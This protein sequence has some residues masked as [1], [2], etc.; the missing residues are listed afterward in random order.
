MWRRVE[1]RLMRR[2][3][4]KA[5]LSTA[6]A[7]ACAALPASAQAWS[8]GSHMATGAI[9]FDDLAADNPG[10]IAKIERIIVA[11]PH[12]DLLAEKAEGLQGTER[13]RVI[14]QWLARWP[15][16]IR[17][18]P[19]FDCYECHYELR[20]VSG[21]IWLWPFRN[22]DA[23]EAY[24]RHMRI[25]A[26]ESAPDR[27][28]AI[29]ISWIM[30]IVGDIQQPLHAGHQV[31][32]DFMQS[33]RAGQLAFV[34]RA[35]GDDAIDLHA[36]WD[37]ALDLP[38]P[39]ENTSRAWSV[40]LPVRFPRSDLPGF[41]YEGTIQEKFGMWLDE[42]MLLARDVAYKGTALRATPD[43]ANAPVMG[44]RETIVAQELSSRRVA[45]GG[46]RIADSFRAAL[47]E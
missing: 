15:D 4:A 29:A 46:Y 19:E 26:D 18:D 38:G 33:D 31:T 43:E 37:Y 27:D 20:V 32:T 13:T 24:D 21:L 22:G 45:M 10:V 47:G 17:D 28:R 39:P 34:R 30:H 42:S 16:D 44:A 11:H 36:F 2:R 3:I 7:L 8:H 5:A 41:D 6:L 9:A 35:E 14:F 40:R 23:S 25:L 12:Y 1:K